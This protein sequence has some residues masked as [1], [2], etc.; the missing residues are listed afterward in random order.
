MLITNFSSG[1]LSPVLNGRVDLQ[2]YYQAASRMENFE[3]IP[4]GGIK[5]RPGTKRLIEITK[6]VEKE[7][8]DPETRARSIVTEEVKAEV[9]IIPFI[10]D[11]L[12]VFIFA[13]ME[14]QLKI[15]RINADMTADYLQRMDIELESFAEI[16]EMQYAQNYD[17]LV[18]VHKNYTPYIIQYDYE[19]HFFNGS[20]MGF[21]FIP[22]VE[23]DDDFDFVMLPAS[24]LPSLSET[25]D[26]HLKFNYSVKI[27][28]ST[29]MTSKEYNS[30]IEKVYCVLNGKLYEYTKAT[31]W[32]NSGVDPSVDNTL[33]TT[34]TKRPGSVAYFNNRLFFAG[35]IMQP[36]AVWASAAPDTNRTRNNDFNVYKKYITVD[37]VLKDADIHTFTCDL[38]KANIDKN[39]G[40]TT[41]VNV[42]QNLTTEGTLIKDAAN[43]F[44]SGSDIPVGTKVI[45]VTANT[46]KI[47]TANINIDEDT[48]GQVMTVQLWRTPL[49]PSA[50]DYEYSIVN[51]NVT[52]ADC[53]FY[54]ELASN[55]N[56]AIKFLS[57]NKYL[58]IGTESSIWSVQSGISALNIQAEMQGRYG[59]D[60]L[61][62]MS[63]A[64]ATIYFAQGK[65]GIREFYYD[66]EA[67]AFQT[68]NIAILAE[69]LLQESTV[70]DF[71][72][73]SNPYSKIIATRRDGTI[74]V[75]LYDKTNGVMGW[76]RMTR[77]AG[78]Y[79]SI[80]VTRG[81]D[82]TDYIFTIIAEGD[83]RYLEVIDYSSPLFMDSWKVYDPEDSYTS[84]AIVYNKTT[85]KTCA[86]DAIPQDFIAEGDLVYI[87][88]RIKSYIKSMPVIANDPTGKKRITNLL[89]R[90]LES[91]MPLLKIT[92]L[93][94]EKFNTIRNV[95]Y[96]GIANITYP[97]SSDRDV[98]FEIETQDV[99][100]VNIL[101]VN[102][103]IA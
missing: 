98:Y 84:G 12:N 5:R 55:E 22:D 100:P 42:T 17:E 44:I 3:I 74:A 60:D 65:K 71:D 15:Y 14:K 26:G 85:G 73:L 49:N 9:R 16:Q 46:I 11:K 90:F 31:G 67:E 79:K 21:D 75:M 20:E 30:G 69:H 53:S 103:N 48:I 24:S 19:T 99:Y 63:V 56:D 36:Q 80:A 13:L 2:Q 93:P 86:A 101:S 18:I 77:T 66:H 81:Q 97:G 43:Y 25:S 64:Q 38:L 58:A 6:T 47:N 40:V 89:I 1:E 23:L 33:F 29:Q 94:D 27:G 92:G 51:T 37:K 35:S 39:T 70:V 7:V 88:Y 10:I 8:S 76:S 102:A 4:T 87:G 83:G 28:E 32:I 52:T 95:P 54:F 72:Y 61:Q 59:S 68:N 62:G 57:S 41:L 96:S 34:P 91:Y 50:E 82:E 45:E 78:A